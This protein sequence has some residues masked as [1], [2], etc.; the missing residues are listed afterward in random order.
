MSRPIHFNNDRVEITSLRGIDRIAAQLGLA[1]NASRLVM[2]PVE[3]GRI[4]AMAE[5]DYGN[6]VDI[7][8]MSDAE[9]HDAMKVS[10][11]NLIDGDGDVLENAAAICGSPTTTT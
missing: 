9:L 6:D 7:P 1:R 10:L 4:T 2:T 3:R 5:D 8:S 11:Q